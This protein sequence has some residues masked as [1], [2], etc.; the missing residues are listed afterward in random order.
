LTL[1][2]M[3]VTNKAAASIFRLGVRGPI[4]LRLRPAD[5]AYKVTVG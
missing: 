5:A 3:A 1:T 2:A 4:N